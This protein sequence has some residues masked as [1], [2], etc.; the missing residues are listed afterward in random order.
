MKTYA[1]WGIEI[2]LTWE[3][4]VLISFAPDKPWSIGKFSLWERN[5]IL[6]PYKDLL[7]EMQMWLSKLLPPPLVP[8]CHQYH[9]Y[10]QHPHRRYHQHH[11]TSPD[12]ILLQW[13][14]KQSLGKECFMG[15]HLCTPMY[16]LKL[17]GHGVVWIGKCN[18]SKP[19]QTPASSS[20]MMESHVLK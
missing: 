2:L 12:A 7:G 15:S 16:S 18:I 14:E 19:I 13:L 20:I 3:L 1:T 17:L 5:E 4:S 8:A 11:H 9:H 6:R 10:H